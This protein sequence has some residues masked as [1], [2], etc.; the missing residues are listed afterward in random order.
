MADGVFAQKKWEIFIDFVSKRRRETLKRRET[1]SRR[2]IRKERKKGRERW[3]KKKRK[4]K[5]RKEAAAASRWAGEQL[6]LDGAVAAARGRW[7]F[8]AGFI[9]RRGQTGDDLAGARE[10]TSL[11]VC[12]VWND[13]QHHQR[14]ISI[15]Q[16]PGHRRRSRNWRGGASASS[17]NN[18]QENREMRFHYFSVFY[19]TCGIPFSC[20]C[21]YFRRLCDDNGPA[22]PVAGCQWPMIYAA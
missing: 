17:R 8:G 18:G 19:F 3:T 13:N 4:E 6:F 16:R 5:E 15:N 10:E 12:A 21:V 9:S 1:E 2:E 20:V 7:L 22:S 11:R 14:A